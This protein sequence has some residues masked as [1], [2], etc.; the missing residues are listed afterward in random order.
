MKERT[1]KNVTAAF[2]GEA[3]A[4]QRLLMYAT[5][6]DREG[7]PQIAKLFR[8]VAVS[9]GVHARR[10]F[11]LL[12]RVADTQTNLERAFESEELVNGVYYPRMLAEAHDDEEKG[13]ALV[14]TQARDVEEGHAKLYKAALEHLMEDEEQDYSVCTVC[15]YVLEGEATEPCPACNAPASRFLPVE[16]MLGKA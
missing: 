16:E 7:L 8:A 2:V 5:R 15:G 14:F 10:H 4:F 3:R 6:A 13:A 11:A 1:E 9:E 12:E